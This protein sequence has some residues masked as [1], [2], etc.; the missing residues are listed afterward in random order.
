MLCTSS[1]ISLC[2]SLVHAMAHG[3]SQTLQTEIIDLHV[4]HKFI[5]KTLT[6][7][8]NQCIKVNTGILLQAL[9]KQNNFLDWKKK[10]RNRKIMSWNIRLAIKS[11]ENVSDD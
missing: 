10:H 11:I 7:N 6:F 1:Y 3:L 8:L 9:E 4:S 2:W 5:Y